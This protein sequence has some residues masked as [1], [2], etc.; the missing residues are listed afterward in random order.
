MSRPCKLDPAWWTLPHLRRRLNQKPPDS[1]GSFPGTPASAR[2]LSSPG[3]PPAA[4]SGSRTP[5]QGRAAERWPSA[6]PS[7]T[8]RAPRTSPRTGSPGT[9]PAPAAGTSPSLPGRWRHS[10]SAPCP[11]FSRKSDD[12][13][14]LSSQANQGTHTYTP[15]CLISTIYLE[16]SKHSMNKCMV[17]D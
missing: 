5:G 3:A 4:A 11:V 10:S 8:A 12:K 14:C 1:C 6:C 2:V 17:N 13:M 15:E 16:Q 7:A 9:A